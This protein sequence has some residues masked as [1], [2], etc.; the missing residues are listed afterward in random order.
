MGL[1]THRKINQYDG[2]GAYMRT[3]DSAQDAANALGKSNK[4]LIQQ[5]AAYSRSSAYGF[6][7]RYADDTHG[8]KG[9]EH[10]D[11]WN[12]ENTKA[13]T[14]YKSPFGI[15]NSLGLNNNGQG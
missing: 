8:F 3:F 7:W 15:F 10:S 11:K 5:T 13:V 4:Y 9:T 12:P 6:I 1:N 14:Q 2:S